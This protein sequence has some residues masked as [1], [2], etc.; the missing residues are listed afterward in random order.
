MRCCVFSS[1][2]IAK[3]GIEHQV[4]IKEKAIKANRMPIECRLLP[5]LA[6]NQFLAEKGQE[7]A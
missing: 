5:D 2:A 1:I 6:L 7:C 3:L 4:S